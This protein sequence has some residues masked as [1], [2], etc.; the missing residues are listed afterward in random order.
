IGPRFAYDERFLAKAVRDLHRL[1][2]GFRD[3]PVEAGW[4]G[5]IDVAGHYLPFFGS[6]DRG[7]VHHGLGF[8]GNGVGPAHLGGQILAALALD[9][10][11]GF[12][13]LGVVTKRPMRFPP[14]PLR[15]AGMLVVNEAI[16]RKDDA[17][18]S[19][20]R[21]NPLVTFV[22]RMPRRLGYNLGPR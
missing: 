6:S 22:A 10:D 12:T 16:R 11:D 18:D 9:A 15:S 3:V 7:N 8:T 19:G 14:E 17:E 13:R 21:P 1:F 5:P 20:R 4:G 2:P